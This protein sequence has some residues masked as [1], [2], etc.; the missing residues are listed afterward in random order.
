MGIWSNIFKTKKD[1]ERKQ[2]KVS[3]IDYLANS[4]SNNLTAENNLT[5]V[6]ICETHARHLSKI[7]PKVMLKGVEAEKQKYL[8]KIL[9]LKPNE[10]M[11]SSNLYET[12]AYDYFMNNLALAFLEWDYTNLKEPLKR[13]YPLDIEKNSLQI[14]MKDGRIYFNFRID[15]NEYFTSQDN[16][17]ILN[18]NANIKEFWGGKNKAIKTILNVFQTNYEG[19]EQAI[20]ASAFI[21]FIVKTP[22][23]M[24]QENKEKRAAEFAASFL[25]VRG[26]G[27]AY[28]D[29]AEDLKQ[30]EDKNKFVNKED[31]QFLEKQ[32]FQYLGGNEKILT[33]TYNEDEFQSYY[34]SVLE[35]FI[36]KLQ[37]EL[38]IK[39]FTPGEINAGNKIVI[40][41]NRLQTASLTTRVAIA[42]R[43][44]KLPVVKPNVINELL[45]L[46]K[47]KEG[48]KEF[49]FL[50][51]KETNKEETGE[52]KEEDKKNE[53]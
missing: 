31:M 2:Q 45:Y 18:R 9:S 13:I 33:S 7:R 49:L 35:P 47:T 48:E 52:S 27:V 4:F 24:T 21:R 34:E 30:V 15:G 16:M 10:I 1:L 32:L 22:T 8:E 6:S 40:D 42:D 11:G 41:S 38:M 44:L 28:V 14:S 19:M 17:I 50:N 37:D 51:Y 5:Y 25:G 46:P 20:K 39:L 3:I 36:L 29:G 43:Y 53:T 26:T 23:L 12:L